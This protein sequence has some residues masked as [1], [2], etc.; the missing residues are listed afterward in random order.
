MVL[1]AAAL[2]SRALRAAAE[3]PAAPG[4]GEAASLDAYA[5]SLSLGMRKSPLSE[6][7]GREES[8]LCIRGYSAEINTKRVELSHSANKGLR[9]CMQRIN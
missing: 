3:H 4:V 9:V 6:T 7:S 8:S 2:L 5:L 1:L